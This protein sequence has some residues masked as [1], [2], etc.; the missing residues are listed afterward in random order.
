MSHDDYDTGNSDNPER[1][2]QLQMMRD[3]FFKHFEDPAERTPYESAEGGYIWIWGG[4]Y[5]A[6]E[7]LDDKFG[8]SIPEDVIEELADELTHICW[9]WAP[10]P[11]RE[12]YDDFLVDDIALISEFHSNFIG[13]I[14][15]IEKLLETE[16]EDSVAG[17]FYRL[18]FVNVITAMET[19]LS[20]AFIRTVIRDPA[21]MRR[22]IEATPE[23]Q[24]EKVALS[25]VFSALEK[26]E[27][28]A[29][30]HLVDVV[31]HNLERVKPMYRDT[32]GIEFPKNIGAV[33]RAIVKRHDIVH[34]NG[35]TK[36]GEDIPISYQDVIA[37][38]AA[39]QAFIHNVDAQLRKDEI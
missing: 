38:I 10:T 34:R 37:L 3:W 36:A 22:F 14:H 23:F 5:D 6:R 31:W 12:D 24:N 28:K 33:F 15:D 35:K 13:A 20:D 4:P 8:D 16:V 19:Y 32:L 11:S 9:E 27:Q 7:E 26:I 39:I 25:E 21:L 1:E 29:Y 30:S 18:L 2:A 17:C